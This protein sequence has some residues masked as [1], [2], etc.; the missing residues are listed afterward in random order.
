MEHEAVFWDVGGVIL[1]IGSIDE[2]Q[3]AFLERAVERYG[4]AFGVDEARDRWRDAMRAHF[5]G[6]EGTTY[7]TARDGRAKAATALFDGDEPDDWRDLFESVTRETVRLNPGA[8]ETIERIHQAGLYQAVV[9]DA[10]EGLA[11]RLDRYGLGGYFDDVTTSEAVGYVKPDDR[12]YERAFEKARAAGVDPR[13][14]VMIGDK[15][16]NDMQGASVHGLTTAAYGAEDGPAVD[17]RLSDLGELLDVL[18]IAGD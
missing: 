5:S 11:E 8:E 9:S 4:L 13:R 16:E 15:Y 14:G 7:R 10:D 2:A 3:T 17:H 18:G 1:D 12:I 6:R